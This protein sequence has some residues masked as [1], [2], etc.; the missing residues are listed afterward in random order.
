M[1]LPA[2][3]WSKTARTDCIVWQ[4]AQNSKGYGC[5]AVGGRSQLAHR[6]A[7]E[8]QRGPIPDDMEIDHL[9]RNRACVNVDHLELVTNRE[10]TRRARRLVIGDRCSRGHLIA[11]DL[12][13]YYRKRN[14]GYECRACR[15]EAMQRFKSAAAEL[16]AAVADQS[17]AASQAGEARG[18]AGITQGA[19][20]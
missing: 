13:L 6:L 15:R 12:D 16:A 17:P 7:W 2:T 14:G 8:D 1:S 5:F 11:T 4:G 20:S 18:A 10:N 19:A 3:F 9:C